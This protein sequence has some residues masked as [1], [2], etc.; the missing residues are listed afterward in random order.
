MAAE[1]Q[2][3]RLVA[4]HALTGKLLVIGDVPVEQLRLYSECGLLRCPSC[5]GELRLKAGAVRQHHFAHV[6]LEL[7]AARYA[8]PE[9]EGHRLGKL[10]LY[11]HFRRDAPAAQ[12]EWHVQ[13]TDQRVDVFVPPNFALEFQQANNTAEE[14]RARQRLYEQAGL[15]AIWFLGQVR[16]SETRSEPMRP[17]SLYDPSPVPR[18]I[19]EAAAGAFRIREMERAMLEAF[20]LLYYLD[21]YSQMLTILVPRSWQAQTLR[22]YRYRLPLS[23]CQ[24]RP[25]GLWTPLHNQLGEKLLRNRRK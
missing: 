13:L 20:P 3:I 5:G 14:W 17:I 9:S 6:S 23:L 15:C 16:Y 8:E 22:A 18:H 19:F 21:P 7:C 24:L 2:G 10:A 1:E 4:Q 12:L 11:R 25:N